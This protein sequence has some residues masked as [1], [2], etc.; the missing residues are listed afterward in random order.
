MG[1]GPKFVNLV[2]SPIPHSCIYMHFTGYKS[3]WLCPT[4]KYAV[5]TC[6]ICCVKSFTNVNQRALLYLSDVPGLPCRGTQE[7]RSTWQRSL[8]LSE[9]GLE[10][11]GSHH[12][13]T[14]T[15]SPCLPLPC[16]DG[17]YQ[18]N[19]GCH[20]GFHCHDVEV[21]EIVESQMK[22]TVVWRNRERRDYL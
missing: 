8:L 4:S 3:L 20:F 5:I 9:G 18:L 2:M 1:K 12:I 16:T 6:F 19:G 7:H 22:H 13:P 10:N 21:H 15:P 11:R 17:G 14:H